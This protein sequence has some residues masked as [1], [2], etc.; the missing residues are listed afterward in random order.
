VSAESDTLAL[1]VASR[2]CVPM[3]VVPSRKLTLPVGIAVPEAAATLAV[4]VIA[5]P[6]TPLA[7][8]ADSVVVV[9]TADGAAFTVTIIAEDVLAEKF[10]SPP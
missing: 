4:N 2:F 10:E 1:P 9:A 8:V 3:E 5:V 7:G 6:A